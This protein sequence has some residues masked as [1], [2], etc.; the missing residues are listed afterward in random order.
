MLFWQCYLRFMLRH[1]HIV[2]FDVPYPVDYGGVSDV[3]YK[4]PALQKT[5]IN[6][7][8]HCFAYGRKKQP[9]LE[10]Y[11]T[12]VQYYK[13]HKN[14]GFRLPY[15]VASRKNEALFCNLLQDDYPILLEGVHC[16]YPLLD[17]RFKGRKLLVRLHNT[18]WIYYRYLYRHTS[19]WFK[20]LYYF[21]ESI[22]LK[23]YERRI[24]G[25]N[26]CFLAMSH[27]DVQLYRQFFL[28][29]NIK[30]IPLF[31]PEKWQVNAREG[32][33][34]F[35]LYHGNL[36]VEENEKAALWLIENVFAQLSIPLIIAGKNPSEK[37]RKKAASYHHITLIA[38]ASP[39]EMETAIAD[40]HIHI[41]PSFNATGIKIK[42]LNALYNGRHC[43]VNKPAVE[44]TNLAQLCHVADTPDE[45]QHKVLQLMQTP[46]LLPEIKRRKRVLNEEFNNAKGAENIRQLL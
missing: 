33:G 19:H 8:L 22:L 30:Y 44:G 29:K 24:A 13:R 36:E 11:C 2:C 40:A 3:F 10:K 21:T 23:N 6:I 37:L 12:S 18:E 43:V 32:W 20:K 15:I 28:C 34:T 27:T 5:G 1:L 35:C 4:L 46:F 7:H 14:L 16:S 26:A 41:L 25:Q 17:A 38:N 39:A 45:M 9:E 31:I 42:L